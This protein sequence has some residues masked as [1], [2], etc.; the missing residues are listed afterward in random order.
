MPREGSPRWR[1]IPSTAPA[2][3]ARAALP[4]CTRAL[5]PSWGETGS[6]ASPRSSVGAELCSFAG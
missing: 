1:G 5:P 4:W 2:P 6:R 3:A